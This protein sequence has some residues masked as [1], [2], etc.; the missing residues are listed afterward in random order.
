[1]FTSSPFLRPYAQASP[2]E[3]AQ[4]LTWLR[5]QLRYHFPTLSPAAWLRALAE[6]QPTLWLHPSREVPVTLA[7]PDLQHLVQHLANSPELPLLH[8]PIHSL[9][10]LE[11]AQQRLHLRELGTWVLPEVAGRSCKPRLRQL[12][13]TACAPAPLAAEVVQAWRWDLASAPALPA[14]LP[15]AGPAPDSAAAERYLRQ[16]R[17]VA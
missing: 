11:L 10:T 4:L 14:G 2:A 8:P 17:A 5:Q 7:P 16:L 15:T 9:A 1:M 6:F 3:R 13:L 12:L